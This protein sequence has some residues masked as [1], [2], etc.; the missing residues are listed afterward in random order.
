[1]AA[2]LK[3]VIVL[4]DCSVAKSV[5]SS[6]LNI[7]TLE[8]IPSPTN[9]APANRDKA[10]FMLISKTSTF[11]LVPLRATKSCVLAQLQ[12]I[13][14]APASV[15]GEPAAGASAPAVEMVNIKIDPKFA[16]TA[17]NFPSEVALALTNGPL[18]PLANG[19]PGTGL[20]VPFAAT[21]NTVIVSDVPFAAIRNFLSGVTA[22][23]IPEPAIPPVA[24][25]EPGKAVRTPVTGSIEKALI[26]LLAVLAAYR[27]FPITAVV[28]RFAAK[29]PPPD[30][31]PP[32]A[33]GEPATGLKVPFTA[34]ENAEIL[35]GT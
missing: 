6:G 7:A 24:N 9:G 34:A 25:G 3:T 4:L 35:L 1:M 11:V 21:L 5:E 12:S 16:D 2:T 32:V 14:A 10:P 19:D 18:A 27:T 23:D 17:R 33:K 29:K 22:S 20:R 13:P 28:M 31:F 8:F 15:N 26:L 30:P